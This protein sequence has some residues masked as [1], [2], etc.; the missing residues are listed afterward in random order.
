MAGMEAGAREAARRVIEQNDELACRRS[1]EQ[2]ADLGRE[3]REVVEYLGPWRENGTN[4]LGRPKPDALNAL[5]RACRW[6]LGSQS[7]LPNAGVTY[8]YQGSPPEAWLFAL[9]AVD[10]QR[11]RWVEDGVVTSRRYFDTALTTAL[12]RAQWMAALYSGL[13]I[14]RPLID[15]P[16]ERDPPRHGR[17]RDGIVGRALCEE[18]AEQLTAGQALRSAAAAGEQ[19]VPAIRAWVAATA[20]VLDRGLT[21]DEVGDRLRLV[22]GGSG[23]A[24]G[25]S[26]PTRRRWPT[27]V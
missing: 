9:S 14:V 18:I 7:P 26:Y 27:P 24:R 19:V 21:N 8:T 12:Q 1:Y 25:G 13:T 2:L 16:E 11:L 6:A 23:S 22:T 10:Q 17:L 3:A 15:V 4:L 20:A 5:R